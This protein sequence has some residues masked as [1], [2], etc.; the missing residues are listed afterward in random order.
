MNALLT[1]LSMRAYKPVS[2]CMRCA[3]VIV[4]RAAPRK[5]RLSHLRELSG[6]SVY[7][8]EHIYAEYD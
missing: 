5:N 2:Q 1:L 3:R 6:L 7:S 8:H 4:Y